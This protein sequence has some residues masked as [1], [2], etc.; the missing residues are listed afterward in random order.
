MCPF[1]KGL[2]FFLF[3][4]LSFF[5]GACLC[6]FPFS[7]FSARVPVFFFHFPSFVPTFHWYPFLFPGV[8]RVLFGSTDLCLVVFDFL[9]AVFFWILFLVSQWFSSMPAGV[10]LQVSLVAVTYCFL[11]WFAAIDPIHA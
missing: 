9:P 5:L 3:F 11:R 2:H 10:S 7:S 4:C 1:L 8:C 6:S